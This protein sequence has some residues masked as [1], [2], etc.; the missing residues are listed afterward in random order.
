MSAATSPS[1]VRV[2]LIGSSPWAEGMYLKA[3]SQDPRVELAA[4]AARNADRL[5]D[6][7]AR[8]K[9]GETFTDAHQLI[10]SPLDAVI[11]A[12]PDSV[13]HE[14]ALAALAAGK[15]VLCEKP[16]AMNA[17]QSSEMLD[18]AKNSGLVNMAMFTFRFL[19]FMQNLRDQVRDLGELTDARFE[20]RQG[21]ARHSEYLWRL[22][23]AHGTGVV[24]D[25]GSH[26]FDLANWFLGPIEVVAATIRN[27]FRKE[28]DTNEHFVALAAAGKT[29]VS[30]VASM[31]DE[32]GDCPMEQVLEFTS[33]KVSIRVRAL[34][35]GPRAGIYTEL[36]KDGV[37]SSEFV[38]GVQTTHY[39]NGPKAFID[40]ILGLDPQ[41]P[42]FAD[43]HRV[44]LQIDK[45][46]AMAK[47][48]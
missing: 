8:W 6:L 38:P 44:Q 23:P 22:D 19:P 16:L 32:M 4:V 24:G 21:Y 9:I 40:A 34:F 48:L 28:I 35:D 18:A 11:I 26:L 3:L 36:R 1:K 15:H 2:G 10:N 43:A 17:A 25:L 37:T 27:E 12:T 14:Y 33:P 29:S 41:I 20:F 45:T 5:S 31:I 13:H 47:T 7:A 39:P 30:F 46:L 42:D